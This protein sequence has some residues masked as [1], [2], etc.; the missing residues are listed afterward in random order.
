M[1]GG[2]KLLLASITRR[3]S[4]CYWMGGPMQGVGDPKGT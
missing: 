3:L 1:W 4:L 2:V